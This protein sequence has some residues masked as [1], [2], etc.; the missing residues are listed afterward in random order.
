MMRPKK[1]ENDK[2]IEHFS[3]KDTQR[4]QR[5]CRT[6]TSAAR[7]GSRA[8]PVRPIEVP[9]IS[10]VTNSR[11]PVLKIQTGPPIKENTL[12]YVIQQQAENKVQRHKIINS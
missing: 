8:G 12:T 6:E 5:P 9:K 10:A 2:I 4:V 11:K 3:R 1:P 7:P